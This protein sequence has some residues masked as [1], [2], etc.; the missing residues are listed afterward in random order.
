MSNTSAAPESSTHGPASTSRP[1]SYSCCNLARCAGRAS[2]PQ[3]TWEAVGRTGVELP[4]GQ[5]GLGE[6]I[7]ASR[8][9]TNR[10]LRE[11]ARCGVIR[12]ER[13]AVHVLAPEVLARR[14][15]ASW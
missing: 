13:S 10:S 12:L 9:T 4:H 15:S 11:L 14:A 2:S 7:G 6:S 5:E 1:S 3:A 8:V